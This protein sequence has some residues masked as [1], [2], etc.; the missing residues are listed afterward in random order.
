MVRLVSFFLDRPLLV[1]LIILT[2]AVIGIQSIYNLQKEGFPNVTFK[3][4]IIT[5]IYPGASSI[6]VELNVTVPI[7]E[8]LREVSGIQELTSTSEDGISTIIA[9]VNED[10]TKSELKKIYDDIDS[11]VSQIGDLP[12][13]LDGSPIIS[14]I[15]SH[16]LPVIEV[17]LSGEEEELR[18]FSN[19]LKAKIELIPEVTQV[20]TIGLRDEEVHILVDPK[21]A[22]RYKVGLRSI[23]NSI[24]SRNLEGSGGTLESFLSEKKVV[25]INKFNHPKDV[26]NTYLRVSDLGY[27]LQLKDL[28]KITTSSKETNLRVRNNGKT[29]VSLLVTK[30]AKA[31]IIET[32]DTMKQEIAKVKKPENI[33]LTY[34]NDQS[35]LTRNRL[36]LVSSNAIVGFILV[37]VVLFLVF[38]WKIAFWTAFGI[39]FSFL[40]SLIL[41]GTTDETL[42]M[43]TLGGF[44]IVLGMLVDDAIVVAEN[45]QSYREKGMSTYKACVQGVKDIWLPV[46]SSSLT[47]MLAF[48]PILSFGGLPGQFVYII[49]L[50]VILALS[51]SLFDSYFILPAH[52]LHAYD[53]K[54]K[55]KKPAAKKGFIVKIETAYRGM[56]STALKGRLT[57]LLF[58]IS[59][60]VVSILCARFFI[61]KDAF[62]QDAAEGFNIQYQVEKGANFEKNTEILKHIEKHLSTLPEE[63]LIG[64]SARMGT[65]STSTNTEIGAQ[66]NLGIV[67][68]YLTPYSERGRTVQK[69]ID[70]LR[71]EMSQNEKLKKEAEISFEVTRI[72]PPLGK[73]FEVQ[74]SSNDDKLRRKKTDEIKKYLSS[75]DG[76]FEVEDDD[77]EGKDELNIKIDYKTLNQAGLTVENVLQILRIAFDGQIISRMTFNNKTLDFRLRLNKQGRGDINFIRD[78]PIQNRNGLFINLGLFVKKDIYPAK[79]S[80]KHLNYKRTTTIFGNIDTNKI[81]GIEVISM[82][83]NKFVENI[84]ENYGIHFG[85]EPI[86]QNKIFSNIGG[87]ALIAIMGVYVIISLVFNSFS[88]PLI[89]IISIPFSV[90]GLVFAALTHGVPLSMFAGIAIVGL[91]GVIV[92]G[93]IVM[94]HTI[95]EKTDNAEKGKKQQKVQMSDKGIIEGA[96]SRLRP[97]ALTTITTVMGIFPTA[98]GIGGTDPFISQMCLFLGYG[99]LFGT[100]IILF[101]IPILL[102]LMTSLENRIKPS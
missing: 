11:T 45:I 33:G 8:E 69:I 98:Y 26:L 23:A 49:P 67:F 74:V 54:V 29:G 25:S 97:I 13:D 59:L 96:V 95:Y 9:E 64:F 52:L 21:L 24:R 40:G 41:L 6:D 39:P 86:E 71:L 63:E 17:A 65:Q 2:V 72:G 14:L 27:S 10:A 93:A 53:D 7:E 16:D 56:L 70:D 15:T 57:I 66:H 46:L 19:L 30:G 89:I 44:I 92:N 87:A 58:F 51:V 50:T 73:P 34:L 28:A 60:F 32:I 43:L 101:L 80:I 91:T 18:R 22:R 47:T 75:V 36:E 37:V 20:D 12:D 61:K 35:L 31:D 62:P 84:D 76:V 100:L 55:K 3:R 94:I 79:S 99:L 38:D 83:E 90:I 88:R 4:V 48:T 81:S 77:L 102:S 42:N 78:L 85:G 1:K 82:V 68:V 5:T